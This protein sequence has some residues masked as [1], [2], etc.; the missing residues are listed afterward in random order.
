MCG[1]SVSVANARTK[2]RSVSTSRSFSVIGRWLNRS[3]TSPTSFVGEEDAAAVSVSDAGASRASAL[4]LK[5]FAISRASAETASPRRSPPSLRI[6]NAVTLMSIESSASFVVPPFEVPFEA[7]NA[8]SLCFRRASR[9][10]RR[11]ASVTRASPGAWSTTNR[12]A[13]SGS[14]TDARIAGGCES[15]VASGGALISTNVSMRCFVNDDEAFSSSFCVVAG[16]FC[17][18]SS[19]VISEAAVTNSVARWWSTVSKSAKAH[20]RRARDAKRSN[21]GVPNHD[22]SA[23]S[24]S[25]SHVFSSVFVCSVTMSHAACVSSSPTEA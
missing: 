7:F 11:R 19:F 20:R 9:T 13:T 21:Q 23:C 3:G 14:A 22:T 4:R 6:G 16:S 2:K 15:G 24:F 25:P 8:L 10:V 1:R 12:I 18:S 17:V 5:R